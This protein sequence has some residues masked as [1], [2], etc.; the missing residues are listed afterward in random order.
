MGGLHEQVAQF[1]DGTQAVAFIVLS[2]KGDRYKWIQRTLICRN[3][4][5]GDCKLNC[6]SA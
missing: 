4:I 6:V 2:D 5:V 3:V 1:L